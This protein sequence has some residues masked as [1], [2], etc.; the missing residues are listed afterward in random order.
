MKA[1]FEA[2]LKDAERA[3]NSQGREGNVGPLDN[4]EKTAKAHERR[5]RGLES[6]ITAIQG[7]IKTGEIK[8]DKS[9][10]MKMTPTE[11]GEFQSFLTPRGLRL[12]QQQHPDLFR[13]GPLRD[14]FLL[15]PLDEI[16]L[17][18]AFSRF[19]RALPE[20]L[21]TFFVSPAEAAV[22]VGCIAPCIAKNWGLCSTCVV[23]AGTAAISA[24][25]SFVGCWNGC[26]SC[27]WY[28]PWNCACKAKCL[29]FFIGRLA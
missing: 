10:L 21:S 26:G 25:N 23:G 8:L 1:A 7:K 18:S 4:F 22:A 19:C 14:G 6:K 2:A 13:P 5:M 29:T 28:K 17:A 15:K 12:H 20:Q 11:R 24:Y 27:K 3:A 16:L 9:L